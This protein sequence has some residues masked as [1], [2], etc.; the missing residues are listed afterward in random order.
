[1]KE[2]W[3]QTSFQF[4]TIPQWVDMYL[5]PTIKLP[6]REPEQLLLKG[7]MI[8]WDDQVKIDKKNKK[9]NR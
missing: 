4:Q 9:D 2:M 5:I 1:M 3:I 7:V 8:S 6:V